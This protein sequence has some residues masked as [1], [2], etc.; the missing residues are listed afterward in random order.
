[1]KTIEEFS[2]G[3]KIIRRIS[4]EEMEQTYSDC[5][6]KYGPEWEKKNPKNDWIEGI[7]SP[8]WSAN[9]IWDQEEGNW[10]EFEVGLQEQVY[11]ATLFR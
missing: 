1:M 6:I 4:L 5:V 8:S 10:I 9:I 11:T 3:R 2:E 7:K